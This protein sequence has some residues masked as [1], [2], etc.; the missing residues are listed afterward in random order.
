MVRRN[1]GKIGN[2]VLPYAES[3]NK[4]DVFAYEK[5]QF[6]PVFGIARHLRLGREFAKVFLCTPAI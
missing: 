5:G 6:A 4:W 1:L 3:G 2:H